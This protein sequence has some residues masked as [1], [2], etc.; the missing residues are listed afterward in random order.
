M[1]DF[2]CHLDLFPNPRQVVEECI[3][4]SIYV[5]S[6]TTTPSAWEGTLALAQHGSRI[7]T[8]LGFHPQLADERYCELALFEEKLPETK[9]VGEVGLDGGPELRKTWQRQQ[10]VFEHILKVCS[11]SGGKV[12]SIHSRR[13]ASPVIDLLAKHPDAG[14]PVLHWFSGNA[15]DLERAKSQGIWFSVGPA[16]LSSRKGREIAAKLPIDRVVTE[17]DAPFAQLEGETLMP[18][19]SELATEALADVWGLDVHQVQQQVLANFDMLVR[20]V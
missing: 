6:V 11:S 14:V 16:M 15:S 2:H 3:A 20:Q 8:A 12:L 10:E 18:W 7:R 1:I 19:M 4:R 13:A 9:Y 5:L 17:T